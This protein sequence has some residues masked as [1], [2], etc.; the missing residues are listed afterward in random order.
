MTPRETVEERKKLCILVP[1]KATFLLLFKQGVPHF[2]FLLAL[3]IIEL[4]LLR[5]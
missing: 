2:H 1:L 3:Q 4:A 5:A